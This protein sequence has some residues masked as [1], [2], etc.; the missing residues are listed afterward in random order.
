MGHSKANLARK[1]AGTT[2]G[3]LVGG[4]VVAIA[5]G[6]AI[7]AL[8]TR[9]WFFG[10][11]ILAGAAALAIFF[12][13]ARAWGF[14]IA[15]LT[16]GNRERAGRLSARFVAVPLIAAAAGLAPLEPVAVRIA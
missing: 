13:G 7:D 4:I 12:A 11:R 6:S 10:G 2:A 9:H 14:R 1:I 15:N 8:I 5:A 3:Y 16:G